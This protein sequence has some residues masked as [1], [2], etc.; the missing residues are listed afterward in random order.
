MGCKKF[1][2]L[3][4]NSGRYVM[5]K[6]LSYKI[7]AVDVSLYIRKILENEEYNNDYKIASFVLLD[8]FIE[9]R[10]YPIMVFDNK[11]PDIK[12]ETVKIR[13]KDNTKTNKSKRV[14]RKQFDEIAEI[15]KAFGVPVLYSDTE[16]D[17][18]C[19]ALTYMYAYKENRN[20]KIGIYG[21]ISDDSDI[22]IYGAK[23][24]IRGL[25]KRGIQ[26]E[27]YVY[28]DILNDTKKKINSIRY[29]HFKRPINDFTNE[30]LIDL[31]IMLGT[32]YGNRKPI[33][34]EDYKYIF[35]IYAKCDMN[36]ICC[37]NYLYINKTIDKERKISFLNNWMHI[38][39]TY[40][41]SEIDVDKLKREDLTFRHPN[42]NK[43]MCIE[44][45]INI[46]PL[47]YRMCNLY[48]ELY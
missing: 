39:K 6:N 34:D 21:S 5:C 15:Y 38:K 40:L 7:F 43:I 11:N 24:L 33:C 45:N 18:L 29:N 1:F 31:S 28:E 9:K 2:R 46:E 42:R 19:A 23:R 3:H 10:M 32:D 25:T 44:T 8:T 22:I 41:Y 48:K 27:E 30:N 12:S 35:E 26:C 20:N 37:A 4:E 14:S 16:A 47:Y 36:V 13:I 17:T